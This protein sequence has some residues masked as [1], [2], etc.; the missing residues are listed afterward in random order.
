MKSGLKYTDKW[1]KLGFQLHMY[2][3]CIMI[4]QRTL[5]AELKD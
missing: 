3:Y 4:M 5:E 2:L 1:N